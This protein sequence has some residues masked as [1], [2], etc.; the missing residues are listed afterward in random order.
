[1]KSPLSNTK[2]MLTNYLKI[3]WRNLLQ[4][5]LYSLIN[6]GSLSVAIGAALLIML[7]V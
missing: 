1:M 5:K 4:Q 6:I 7:W 2:A 3:A